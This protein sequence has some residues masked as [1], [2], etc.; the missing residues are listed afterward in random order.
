[1]KTYHSY[2][3]VNYLHFGILMVGAAIAGSALYLTWT[4]GNLPSSQAVLAAQ[5]SVS[6]RTLSFQG[7]LLDNTN[8]PITTETPLRF[9]L[10]NNPTATGAAQ[11]WQEKQYIKPDQNG[12]FTATLGKVSRLDQDLFRDNASLYI[13]ISV[14]GNT[15]LTPRE[16]IPTANYAANSQTVE[17]LKPITDSPDIA[18]NVLLALDSSGNLTIGGS[19]SHTFQTTGGQLNLSGQALLLTTNPGSNGNI[20]IAPDGS[21]IIDLQKPLQNTSNYSSP[22][23]IPGAVE[24]ADILSVLATTSS[25][26]AL[27]VN[28]NGSGDIVSARSNGI[29]KFRLDN[30]G[31]AFFGGNIILKG[32]TINSTSTAFDIGGSIVTHLTIGSNATVLSLGASNGVTSIR[33]SLAVDGTTTLSGAV[34]TSGLLTANAG[35][36]IPAGQKLTLANFIPGAIPFID[37]NSQVVQDASRFNWNDGNKT[38]NVFGSL[39][40]NSIAGGTCDATPGTITSKT[41]NT[42]GTADLAE[43]YVSS[44]NLQPG[45]VV[46]AEGASNTMAIMKSTLPYQKQLIGI[47]SSNPGITLNSDAKTDYEHP[48]VYPLALQGRVPV[49]VSS[50]NG[51]IEPGDDLTSSSI[52]GVAM[53]ASASGQT[54]GKA[55]EGYA[56]SDPQAVGKIMAFVNLSY[57]SLPASI[58]ESGDIIPGIKSPNPE[59]S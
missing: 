35:L 12:Y 38:L 59:T 14:N 6:P 27:V 54:V 11:L 41:L 32:D 33:N 48:N 40:V 57:Q 8:T 55:L 18:Q 16:E 31:N 43:D 28:Q 1:Y 56:N 23:G 39:C 24:V 47:V 29:D 22:G 2:A 52:P 51:P 17:G 42:T 21:G 3:F 46:V 37:A 19:A 15:E 9:T 49:K 30:G 10:Y 34:N 36:T 58:S 45:D 25:Q 20:Q 7:R 44:E 4:D 53:L 5:S 50:S 13:G 26:S